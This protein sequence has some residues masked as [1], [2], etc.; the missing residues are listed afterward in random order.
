VVELRSR[1]GKRAM[2]ELDAQRGV[3]FSR[4][5]DEVGFVEMFPPTTVE[6]YRERIWFDPGDFIK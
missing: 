6:D 1:Q 4:D 3:A 5:D 2:I